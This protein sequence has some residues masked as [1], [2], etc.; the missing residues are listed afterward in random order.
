[1][2]PL[3]QSLSTT[4]TEVEANGLSISESGLPIQTVNHLRITLKRIN[5]AGPIRKRGGIFAV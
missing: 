4:K 1:M 3:T 5:E 2:S